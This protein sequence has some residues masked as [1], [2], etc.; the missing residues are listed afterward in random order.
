MKNF[1]A[2]FFVLIA[3]V[4]VEIVVS[5]EAKVADM[6]DERLIVDVR[7]EMAFD[8]RFGWE[9]FAADVAVVTEKLNLLINLNF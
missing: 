7:F 4:K 2:D 3:N 1:L 6:T 9:S 8:V 5:L